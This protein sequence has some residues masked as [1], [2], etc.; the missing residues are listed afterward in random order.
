[1]IVAA[2]PEVPGAVA[3]RAG[4]VFRTMRG[5]DATLLVEKQEGKGSDQERDQDP[6]E[7]RKG[8]RHVHPIEKKLFVISLPPVPPA[9]G[10][11]PRRRTV[12][13]TTAAG[14]LSRPPNG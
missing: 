12:R 14:W 10:C 9:F 6:S 2:R 11:C 5:P 4:V 13:Q 7:D 8:K 1:M 3:S